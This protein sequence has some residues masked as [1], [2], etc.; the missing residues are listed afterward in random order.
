MFI[1]AVVFICSCLDVDFGLKDNAIFSRL[2]GNI[3][4]I[5]NALHLLEI[6]GYTEENSKIDLCNKTRWSLCVRF[7][8][9]VHKRL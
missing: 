2:T 8:L 9:I 3:F 4:Q 7:H 6:K 5:V 1:Q